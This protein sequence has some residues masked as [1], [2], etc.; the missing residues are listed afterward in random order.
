M[1]IY[2]R[3][4]GKPVMLTYEYEKLKYKSFI[5]ALCVRYACSLIH[6]FNFKET[7]FIGNLGYHI[8][9]FTKKII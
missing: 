5:G 9:K 3:Y 6:I 2:V 8:S 4:N 7:I 1:C